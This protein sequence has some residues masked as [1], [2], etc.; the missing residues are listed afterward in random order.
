MSRSPRPNPTLSRLTSAMLYAALAALL[1]MTALVV[2][3]V[4][5]RNFF[6]L[7]LPWADELARFCGIAL[8]FL[9]IPHLLLE[10]KHIA[11]DMVVELLPRLARSVLGIVNRVL[12]LAFCAVLLWAIYKFLSR[13][14][15][16]S[17]PALGIPNPVYY[18]PAILGFALFAV[19]T[20][21][22]LFH[23][24]VHEKPTLPEPDA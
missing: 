10:D 21:Y 3:Q 19:V 16:I 9:A 8:V 20:I 2:V 17:T 4:I 5:C 1:A 6:D 18:L 11:V 15:Q 14:W 23:T 13:A 22:R 12:A 24:A 7:G